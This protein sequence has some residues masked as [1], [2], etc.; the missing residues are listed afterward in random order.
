MAISTVD[1]A[2]VQTI[3]YTSSGD[4]AV[5]FMSLCN[6]GGAPVVCDIHIIPNGDTADTG[7][8]LIKDLE[9][10]AGDTYILY[11]GGEKLLFATGDFVSVISDIATVTAITSNV[12]I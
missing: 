7:N 1:V 3:T 12:G 5:T 2:V 10:I 9:I 4:T 6:H 11:Q 8:L